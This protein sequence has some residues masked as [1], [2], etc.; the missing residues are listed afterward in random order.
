MRSAYILAAFAA[1]SLSLGAVAAEDMVVIDTFSEVNMFNVFG[2]NCEV[3]YVLDVVDTEGVSRED[4]KR[5]YCALGHLFSGRNATILDLWPGRPGDEVV[6]EVRIGDIILGE[7]V[8][9]LLEVVN[10]GG[11]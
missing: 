7:F 5:V 9:Y 6:C 2:P 8:N 10:D 11:M 1:I 3:N 4:Q